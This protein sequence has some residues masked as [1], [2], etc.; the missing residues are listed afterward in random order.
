M[1]FWKEWRQQWLAA[2]LLGLFC[3]GSYLA[4]C[5]AGQWQ[6][7]GTALLALLAVACLSLGT[8]AFAAEAE[9]RAEGFLACLPLPVWKLLLTK[10][11]LA[12]GLAV[13]CLVAPTLAVTPAAQEWFVNLDPRGDLIDLSFLQRSLLLWGFVAAVGSSGMVAL[14][15]IL[16]RY[17]LGSMG[18][19][20]AGGGLGV[21]IGAVSLV[22]AA[23]VAPS[24]SPYL[25]LLV[26]SMVHLWLAWAWLGPPRAR[27]LGWRTGLWPTAILLTPVVSFVF[28]AA[29]ERVVLECTCPTLESRLS[30]EMSASPSPDGQTILVT[31]T[32]RF[33]DHSRHAATWL[34]DADTG[35]SRRLGSRWRDL[36]CPRP[37]SWS[38]DSWSPDGTQVRAYSLPILM[39][40]LRPSDW[41]DS[42]VELT[43]RLEDGPGVLVER[44]PDLG[45]YCSH[46]LKDGTDAR[47][48]PTAWEFVSPDTGEVRRCLHPP[49][50]FFADRTERLFWT[51]H[52]ALAA[53]SPALTNDRRWQVWRSAP[54]LAEAQCQEIAAGPEDGNTVWWPQAVAG[55]GQWV[56]AVPSRGNGVR[57]LGLAD[58]TDRLLEP[59]GDRQGQAF[60][61]PDSSLLVLPCAGKLRVWNLAGKRWKPDLPL[62][63]ALPLSPGGANR[64]RYSCR[65]SPGPPWRVAIS[66]NGSGSVR[67]ADLEQC[68]LTEVLSTE[69]PEGCDNWTYWVSWFGNDRLLVES[70][71][72]YTL[73]VVNADGSGSRQ[74]L[75]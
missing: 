75:P 59:Q 14:T 31:S 30:R 4:Y 25:V 12:L 29:Y 8:N 64:H 9:D 39:N 11:L 26:W 1:L 60:F 66:S 20:L 72:D 47:W 69:L 54:E 13:L 28:L 68:A 63:A 18:I 71:R 2:L 65:V 61:T 41:P 70:Q 17:G 43:Y 67:V 62:P 50:G 44:R 45:Y 6:G 33:A 7:D 22:A 57:L 74:V 53:K 38:P 5:R 42:M 32:E 10:Y 24:A 34:V 52:G 21:A 35:R 73:W 58:G 46:W 51:D 16:A 3:L 23:F 56:L 19:W 55:D 40:W 37:T 48:T 15:A 49:G 36:W 27:Q